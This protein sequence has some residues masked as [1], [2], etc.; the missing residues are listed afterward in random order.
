MKSYLL[1]L[2]ALMT[3]NTL[4]A[5]M[6][7]LI[8]ADQCESIVELS[9][10]EYKL[11]LFLEIGE[12]DYEHFITIIPKKYHDDGYLTEHEQEALKQ[13]FQETFVLKADGRFL[14]GQVISRERIPRIY[15]ASLYTGKVDTLNARTSKFVY[16]VRIDYN[17]SK[18]KVLSIRPPILKGDRMTAANIGFLA[19]HQELPVNDLR[20]LS[21]EEKLRL[22][23]G[24][25]WYSK[26]DNPNLARHHKS[27]MMSFLY[28]EPFEVRHEV[29]VRIKDLDEWIDLGYKPGMK[30][31]PEDLQAVLDKVSSFLMERNK[32]VIDGET[33]SPALDRANFVE[34]KLSGIQILEEAKPLDYTSA[35]IGVIFSF[36]RKGIPQRAEVHWDMWSD[37]SDRIPCMMTDPAGPMPYDITLDDPVLVWKNYLKNYKEPTVAATEVSNRVLKVPYITLPI[38]LFLG[39][40]TLRNRKKV[41]KKWLA[42]SILLIVG[43]FA[44]IIHFDVKLP[45]E[46]KGNLRQYEA[47]SIVSSLLQNTYRSFDYKEQELV[48]DKL[49][50]SVE[51]EVLNEIY[52]DHI[53]SMKVQQ[54]GGAQAKVKSITIDSVEVKDEEKGRI[55]LQTTWNVMGTV[56]H[57]GHQ[58]IRKN[59]YEALIYIAAIEGMWKVSDLDILE[60]VRLYPAVE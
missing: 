59:R 21:Q 52:L 36:P 7:S 37:K 47:A 55:P 39:Y 10:T 14:E 29:L 56:G 8:R 46:K 22:D 33:P 25:P 27:S 57:W 34:V 58:H 23:W 11:S 32:V 6:I 54:A 30:I 40:Q 41:K 28:V 60:E 48:Y 42:Y 3:V 16:K 53:R 4:R 20:Y 12:K 13:F 9:I 49:Q 19:Y 50:T 31:N 35:I 24:D 2:L 17:I 43:V 38:F 26:F 1:F 15:R 5:D 45:L 44:S 18:P 51:G